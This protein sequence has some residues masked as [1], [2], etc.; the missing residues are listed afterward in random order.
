ML[1]IFLL[2][3]LLGVNNKRAIFPSLFDENSPPTPFSEATVQRVGTFGMQSQ[4]PI[5]FK[6]HR[7]EQSL[8]LHL[9]C[10][11]NLN[12]VL[13]T[14]SKLTAHILAKTSFC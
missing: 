9:E 2:S 11:E 1:L 6:V 13:P 8:Q 4:T 12:V 10:V 3:N 5:N 14:A 7:F